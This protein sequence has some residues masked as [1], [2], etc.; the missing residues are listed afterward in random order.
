MSSVSTLYMLPA[1]YHLEAISVTRLTIA[2]LQCLYSSNPY[3]LSN[4]P[5]MQ[6]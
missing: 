3:V 2:V 4:G 1:C 6:E 5:Y